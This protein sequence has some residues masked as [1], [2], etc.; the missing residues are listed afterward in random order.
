[1]LI[2]SMLGS[3]VLGKASHLCDKLIAKFRFSDRV[4]LICL[5]LNT[6]FIQIKIFFRVNAREGCRIK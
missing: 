4:V 6:L 1:M 2:S 5:L 3:E